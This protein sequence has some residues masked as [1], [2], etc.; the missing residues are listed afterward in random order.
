[1]REARGYR[2]GCPTDRIRQAE[3]QRAEDAPTGAGGPAA[4]NA[5]GLTK[6]RQTPRTAATCGVLTG[7]AG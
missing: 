2:S 6:Q 1:M 3:A 7:L 4:R 5:P